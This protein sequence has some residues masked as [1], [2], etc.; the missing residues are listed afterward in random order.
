[1][2]DFPSTRHLMTFHVNQR[3]QINDRS[4]TLQDPFKHGRGGYAFHDVGG[5]VPKCLVGELRSALPLNTKVVE[6]LSVGGDW[7]VPT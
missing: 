3:T 6:G 4:I 7:A 1:M 2:L 5:D